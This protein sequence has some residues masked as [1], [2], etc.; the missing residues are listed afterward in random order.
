MH[1]ITKSES[2]DG[3]SMSLYR[4]GESAQSWRCSEV[5]MICGSRVCGVLMNVLALALWRMATPLVSTQ[6][7]VHALVC[8][9]TNYK[10]CTLVSQWLRRLVLQ[11]VPRSSTFG[12][13]IDSD[14]SSGIASTWTTRQRSVPRWQTSN[15]PQIALSNRCSSF[16]F[17]LRT[18]ASILS[19]GKRLFITEFKK[20]SFAN[21]N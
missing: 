10:T 5:G 20:L 17:L 7:A 9:F 12:Q 11:T 8:C 15:N 2:R 18:G 21:D 1:L 6:S 4:I 3:M 19:A 16:N 13:Q 14:S